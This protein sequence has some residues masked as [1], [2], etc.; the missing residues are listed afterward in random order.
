MTSLKKE[1]IAFCLETSS[2]EETGA[3]SASFRFPGTFTAFSGHFPG[4][5][6]LPA[7]VQ[8]L[9]A[10]ILLEEIKRCSLE[11]K[12]VE[13]AK[14]LAEI[15]P[16]QIIRIECKPLKASDKNKWKVQL[17][18]VDSIAASFLITVHETE[19]GP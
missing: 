14:F 15:R 11:L 13:K 3:I 7:F 1:I 12:S 2:I 9:T 16:D 4:Y 19:I 8:I 5:P 17:M 18:I 10:I 6:I